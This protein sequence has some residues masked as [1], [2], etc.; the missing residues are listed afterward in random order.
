MK[1]LKFI[2]PFLGAFLFPF[3]AQAVDCNRVTGPYTDGDI[4]YASDYESEQNNQ[5]SCLND[6]VETDG[7]IITGNINFHGGADLNIY[8]D[9]GGTLEAAIDG[10]TGNTTINGTLGL[11]GN[12]TLSSGA[13]IYQYS[14]SGSTLIASSN[15]TTGDILGAPRQDGAYG[16][17]LNYSSP[18]LSV[19]CRNA[20]CSAANPGY[21]VMASTT[22]GQQVT[23]R[24]TAGGSMVDDNGTSDLTN[25]GF[26]ITES[27]DW[28]ADVPFFLYVVNRANSAVNGADG[29]S[30]FFISRNPALATT[31]S[32]ANDIG[33]TGAIPTNDS[34]DV[35]LILDDV[36][37]ANY[38]SLPVQLIGIF[39]MQWASATTDWTV[40][41]IG[42]RDG[43]GES[44]IAKGLQTAWSYPTAQNG[45]GASSHLLANGG[46]AP[47]FQSAIYRYRIDRSGFCEIFVQLYDDGGTDGAGAVQAIV[48][49]PYTMI[50]P[51]LFNYLPVGYTR[52]QTTITS[53]VQ[54]LI[55]AITS[56]TGFDLYYY[57]FS[58]PTSITNAMYSSGFREINFHF[59]YKAF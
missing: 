29:N 32:S 56:T 25:L 58:G 52:S 5:I 16:L 8:S 4:L 3:L 41:S 18:T 26:G 54:L 7:D 51:A 22:A 34:Q 19:Q 13:N 17:T 6:R 30:A 59:T 36:T 35:I 48:T 23:L 57:G 45:A 38:T 53:G 46:T 31:P 40:V 42:S 1:N 50:S 37:V 15:G 39:R 2:S 28:A 55:A 44:A 33:D 47:R 10:A 43:I 12:L 9:T 11:T 21:V 20:A 49:T 24:V 14:D 27:V